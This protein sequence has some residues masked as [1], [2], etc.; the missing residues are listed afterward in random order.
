MRI[1][2]GIMNAGISDTFMSAPIDMKNSA[3]NISR[4][5]IVIILA[6]AALLLSATS[7]L[8]RKAPTTTDMPRPF[9]RKDNPKAM[10]RIVI[11]S[12]RIIVCLSGPI[13]YPG[14]ELAAYYD[15]ATNKAAHYSKDDGD[16]HNGHVTAS[17]NKGLQDAKSADGNYVLDYQHPK[18]ERRRL[19]AY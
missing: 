17:C 7:T 13:Y 1:M 12:E 5:G 2:A 4:N 8:A 19:I 14:D 15:Y 11:R 16:I 3:E 6:T 9:A 10:L 18:N